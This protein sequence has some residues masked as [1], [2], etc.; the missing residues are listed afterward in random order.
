M[1][2]EQLAF[3]VSKPEMQEREEESPSEMLLRVRE[4]LSQS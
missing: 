1:T 4:R 2:I 3:Q